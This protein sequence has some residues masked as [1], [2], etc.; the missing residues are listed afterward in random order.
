MLPVKHLVMLAPANFGSPLAD[1]GASFIGRVIK[2][3]N[4]PKAF[5]VGAM[6]LKGLELASPYTWELAGKD[7]FVNDPYFGPGRI[8]GTVLVG[9]TGYTGVA[10]AANEPGSDGTVRV[11]TANLNAARMQVDLSD[12]NAPTFT[13]PQNI[14]GTVG[15]LILNG[16]NHGTICDP[17]QAAM[18]DALVAGLQVDDAGFN[19]YCAQLQTATQAVMTACEAALDRYYWGYQNTVVLVKDQFG[20][21]VQDYFLEFYG[22]AA[23]TFWETLFHGDVIQDV[24]P[25]SD[26]NG[27]RAM[28]IDT[29]RLQQAMAGAPAG[30]PLQLSLTASPD[31]SNHEAGYATFSNAGSAEITIPVGQIP[32]LFQSNRTLLVEVT[33]NRVQKDEIF[34]LGVTPPAQVGS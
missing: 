31:I 5:E 15:F 18:M 30:V 29:T 14:N 34:K 28:L 4:S 22:P 6:L 16:L 21:H 7:L 24:H 26:D 27:Y 13:G 2:G 1:K 3:W 25:Y 12:V 11:S 19:A 17:N 10:A 8:L 23:D 20:V 33:I 32:L 9:N